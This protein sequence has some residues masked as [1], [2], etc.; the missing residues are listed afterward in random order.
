MFI[1]CAGW[2]IPKEER[3]HFPEAGS[4]LERYAQVFGAVEINSSFYRPHR[5]STYSRWADSVP[6]GFRFSVKV[7]K[8]ITH[9]ARLKD[10]QAAFKRFHEECSNLGDKLGCLLVQMPPGLVFDLQVAARFFR[11]LRQ[12]TD[13]DVVCEPRHLSWASD[14]AGALLAEYAIG[15]V[16]ADP[17]PVPVNVAR[18]ATDSL[19]YFR[20]HGSPQVY[21]SSYTHE[22]LE[23]LASQLRRESALSQNCWCI[24]DNTAAGA[25]TRNALEL[26]EMLMPDASGITRAS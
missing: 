8:A 25:A 7:P 16:I 9:T 17:S 11:E 18:A 19:R 12:T 10:V 13:V 20:L 3:A 23:E 14:E 2:S 24:F 4:L 1:G 22:Y 6:D 26:L 5:C 21:Y 15:R